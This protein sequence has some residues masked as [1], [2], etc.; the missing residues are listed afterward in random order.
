MTLTCPPTGPMES[1]AH[2]ALRAQHVE[3]GE[4]RQA[5]LHRDEESDRQQK[6]RLFA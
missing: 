5:G 6:A 1:M 2:A 4:L 3:L